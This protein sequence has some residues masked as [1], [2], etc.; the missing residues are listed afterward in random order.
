MSSQGATTNRVA[1]C[2]YG[3]LG[4]WD[5]TP[6]AL[7]TSG[8]NRSVATYAALAHTTVQEHIV[9][10]NRRD[11]L[12]VDVFMHSWNPEVG[13][14]LD[15]LYS[16]NLSLHQEPVPTL[17]R[18]RSSHLS[19]K[20]VLQL[21]R[22]HEV[23]GDAVSLVMLSRFDV[24]WY[25]DLTLRD[26]SP[27]R[28]WLPHHCQPVLGLSPKDEAAVH[29]LCQSDRGALMEPAYTQRTFGVPLQ[30]TDNYNSF[31]LD[32][33]LIAPTHVA[34]SFADIYHR[35]DEYIAQ[36]QQKLGGW[37][38]FAAHFFWTHH[39]STL[40]RRSEAAVAR[41]HAPAPPLRVDFILQSELDFNLAR[42]VGFG[43]DC[44]VDTAAV[45]MQLQARIEQMA[46]KLLPDPFESSDNSLGLGHAPVGT[47]NVSWLVSQCPRALS[48]GRRLQCPWYSRR[49]DG[50]TRHRVRSLLLLA[51][52]LRADANV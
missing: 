49:C 2:L 39:I 42:F 36:M 43:N 5:A 38:P 3:K 15:A 21:L 9:H 18:V 40:L 28:I 37:R 17:S 12:Q 44:A 7:P 26:L 50:T 41:G 47:R 23:S 19:L 31:V 4:S 51:R 30:R 35:H 45:R 27:S 32:Y 33:W 13:P 20:R 6:S 11:G 1:L 8:Y 52:R 34:E 46:K 29:G 25:K 10:A 24:I 14:A 48:T 16:P 22:A